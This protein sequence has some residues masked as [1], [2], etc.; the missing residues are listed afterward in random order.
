MNGQKYVDLLKDKLE[1]HMNVHNCNIFKQDDAPCHKS[2]IVSKFLKEKKIKI[3][4]WPGKSPD[5]NPGNSPDL[6]P[7]E[8]LWEVLKNKVAD[9]QPSSAKGL[10]DDIK[11]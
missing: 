8:N 6:N 9:K 7:I 2:K 11:G 1:L 10:N 5:L 4:D 3:L